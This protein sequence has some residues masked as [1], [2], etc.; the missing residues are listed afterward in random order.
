MQEIIVKYRIEGTVR[1]IIMWIGKQNQAE[2]KEHTF[3]I[4]QTKHNCIKYIRY[5]NASLSI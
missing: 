1:K 3:L 2:L 4:T 5:A